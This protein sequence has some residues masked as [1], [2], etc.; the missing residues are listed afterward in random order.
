MDSRAWI[1]LVLASVFL[2]QFSPALGRALEKDLGVHGKL[3]EI[4]EEDMLSYVRR[5]AGE[6]DMRELRESMERKL[7]ESYAQYS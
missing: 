2:I 5:K 3:Y 1:S 7:E 4:K 6:I